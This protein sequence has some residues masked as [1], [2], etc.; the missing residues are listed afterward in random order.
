[1]GNISALT[2]EVEQLRQT[3]TNLTAQLRLQ[4]DHIEILQLNL[5]QVQHQTESCISLKAAAHSQMLAAESQTKACES[6]QLFLNKQLQKCKLV[7]SK[8]SQQ[9]GTSSSASPLGSV[10]LMLLICSSLHLI[11]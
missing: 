9:T 3:E 8:D 2:E 1:M 6:N 10:V 7:N 5:T 11:T 4:E